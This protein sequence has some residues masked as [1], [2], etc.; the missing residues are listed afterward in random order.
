MKK[1]FLIT[2]I[3]KHLFCAMLSVVFFASCDEMMK[4]IIYEGEGLIVTGVKIG[5]KPERGKYIYYT[6]DYDGTIVVWS[7][8]EF[9]IGDTLL[10][11]KKIN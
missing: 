4:Q 1:K 8:E 11:S 2:K 5:S 9:K 10:L 7:N 3:S 6:K